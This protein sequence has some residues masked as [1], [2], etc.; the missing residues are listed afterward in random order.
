MVSLRIGEN[1]SGQRLDKFLRKYFKEAPGSFL[2]KMLRKKNITCNGKKA[3]GREILC[4]GDEIQLFLADE[5]VKKFGGRLSVEENQQWDTDEQKVFLEAYHRLG[6]LEV[7]FENE[8]LLVVNKPSGILTQKAK[9]E[10]ISLN[11]WLLGYLISQ[12]ALSK[13]QLHTFRPSVCNRLDRNT[14]GLVVC[15]KTLA[16]SQQM[17]ELLKNRTLHKYYYTYVKGQVTESG[18]L[19]GYWRKDEKINRSL[20]VEKDQGAAYVATEYRPLKV[21]TDRTLLEVKLITGK[22]HQIRLQLS[23]AGHP[24][25][26]DYKYGDPKFNDKYKKKFQISSHLLHACRLE[27]PPMDGVLAALSGMIVE[28]G[29]PKTF[30][31]LRE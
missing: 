26:G 1:E 2:Y 11:E 6:E 13:A 23:A 14:S 18:R 9:S 28:A 30:L 8:H 12:K 29:V 7:V 20:L 10:D 4:I 5:T 27:F 15:G 19:E 22:S 21:F 24:L 17:G 25:L 16:G 31:I 3:D